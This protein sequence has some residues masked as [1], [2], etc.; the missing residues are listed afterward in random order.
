MTQHQETQIDHR[1][2]QLER[3][4][5]KLAAEV[6]GMRARQDSVSNRVWDIALKA[7]IPI[8]FA[9]AG[10]MWHTSAEVSEHELEDHYLRERLDMSVQSLQASEARIE[11]RIDELPPEW[12][13]DIVARLESQNVQILQR[14]SALEAVTKDG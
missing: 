6:R 12:L 9:I 10:W 11:A 2:E 7:T 13:K 3:S 5:E 4:V 14:L 8:V 1:L